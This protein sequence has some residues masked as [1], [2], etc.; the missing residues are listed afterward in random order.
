MSNSYPARYKGGYN[1]EKQR[2]RGFG[3]LTFP[4]KKTKKKGYWRN[5]IL[6]IDLDYYKITREEIKK[7]KEGQYDVTF[8]NGVK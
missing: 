8:K 1:I 7:L 3:V 4:D 5:S 2:F 6:K